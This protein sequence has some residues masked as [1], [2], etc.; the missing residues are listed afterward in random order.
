MK[1]DNERKQN[2]NAFNSFKMLMFSKKS[3][4]EK[5]C[6]GERNVRQNEP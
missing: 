6:N 3:E 4:I 1:R 5:F 2:A